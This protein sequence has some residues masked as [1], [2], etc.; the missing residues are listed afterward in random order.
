MLEALPTIPDSE[1]LAHANERTA[2]ISSTNDDEDSSPSYGSI[3][4][5][6]N[7]SGRSTPLPIGQLAILYYLQ[8]AEPMSSQ[9]ILPFI[10]EVCNI[11]CYIEVA[12]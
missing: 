2:L 7:L 6:K 12:I 11:G 10:N 8:L 3:S 4:S 1:L 9:V 5:A